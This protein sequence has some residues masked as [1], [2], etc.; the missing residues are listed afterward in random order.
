MNVKIQDVDFKA[1]NDLQNFVTNKV[2][3]LER[4]YSDIIDADVVM[5]L[6]KPETQHNKKVRITLSVKGP[7]LF[8]EKTADSFEQATDEACEALEI[9]L[10]KFKDRLTGR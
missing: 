2:N 3:K 7:D 10:K 8:A 4:Y 9:Q 6:V 1:S 5:T